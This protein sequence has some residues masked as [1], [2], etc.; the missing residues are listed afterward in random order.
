MLNWDGR[1]PKFSSLPPQPSKRSKLFQGSCRRRLA[2]PETVR[3]LL[4]PGLHFRKEEKDGVAKFA[5]HA[6]PFTYVCVYVCMDVCTYVRM[7]V[8]MYVRT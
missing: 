4:N 3:H 8:C 5:L 7:N 6:S 2:S 1:K